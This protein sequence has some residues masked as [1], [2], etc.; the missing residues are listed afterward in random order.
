MSGSSQTDVWAVGDSGG[1]YPIIEHW[2]GSRWSLL[3]Q[4]RIDGVLS[5]VAAISPTDAWAAGDLGDG[6]DSRPL[7]ENWDGS[8]WRAVSAP[9][10]GV[11]TNLTGLTA[12]SPND[13]W[14]V[15]FYNLASK[16][17]TMHWDGQAWEIV[18]APDGVLYGVS[19]AAS[20]D[21]WAVGFDF[22][23][24]PFAIHWDGAAWSR[25]PV[26]PPPAGGFNLLYDVVTLS[27]NEAWTVGI[28][29]FPGAPLVERWDGSNWSFV[30]VPGE[31]GLHG[32]S[33]ASST[34]VWAVGSAFED[35]SRPLTEHWNG[36][37]WQIFR[38]PNPGG[39]SG[40]EAVSAVSSADIW[41]VGSSEGKG[42]IEYSKGPCRAEA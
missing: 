13:I 40:L 2:D 11:Y 24:Q 4:R 12:I 10:P 27:T 35:T 18:P 38:A 33:A 17:L 26:D 34:D 32:V 31:G 25:V 36:I 5:A 41:A 1:N 29:G 42:L 28:Y 22:D 20:D 39:N 9:S 14:A 30:Q 3:Q 21:V 8:R 16:A 23:Y 19:G 37:D 6:S 7:F 15:G